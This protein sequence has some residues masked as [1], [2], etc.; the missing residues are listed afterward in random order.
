MPR[1]TNR[2]LQNRI[3]MLVDVNEELLAMNRA[4]RKR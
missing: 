4:M 2:V 1:I 3:E